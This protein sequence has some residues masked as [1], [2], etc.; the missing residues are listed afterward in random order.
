MFIRQL[1]TASSSYNITQLLNPHTPPSALK[2]LGGI[3]SNG[4]PT[5]LRETYTLKNSRQKNTALC[6][7]MFHNMSQSLVKIKDGNG[8][9]THHKMMQYYTMIQ[10]A[11]TENCTALQNYGTKLA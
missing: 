8:S 1:E 3:N 5:I 10:K 11:A 2:D 7:N 9:R 4:E 6:H